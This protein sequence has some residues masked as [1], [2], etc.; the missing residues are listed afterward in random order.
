MSDRILFVDDD[1]NILDSFGALCASDSPW[2]PPWA[3]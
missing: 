3:P 1:A 2:I